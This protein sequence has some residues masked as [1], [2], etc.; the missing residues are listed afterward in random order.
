MALTRRQAVR[1]GAPTPAPTAAATPQAPQTAADR[2]WLA[3]LFSAA[4]ELPVSREAAAKDALAKEP[5]RLVFNRIS[6]RTTTD[7]L[8]QIARAPN[9][10]L[11][12][13]ETP[14]AS[15][16]LMRAS[17]GGLA[18]ADPT[19]ALLLRR[20]D[21]AG[22][23][24]RRGADRQLA[25]DDAQRLAKGAEQVKVMASDSLA[26]KLEAEYK[27]LRAEQLPALMQV[28]MVEHWFRRVVL[29]RHLARAYGRPASAALAQ[30][31]LFDPDAD[32]R[33]EAI[34]SLQWRPATEYRDLLLRGFE[35][36]WPVVAEHA[37]E[38]LSALRRTETVP[39]LVALLDA[40]DPQAPYARG[41]GSPQYIKEMVRID[42]RL[43]CLMCHPP[44]FQA[45]DP[46]RGVIPRPGD[47]AAGY[48]ASPS[49]RRDETFVRADI[50]YLKQ[51]YSVMLPADLSGARGERRFDLFVRE[52]LVTKKDLIANLDRVLT[53]QSTQ[54]ALSFALRE[55]TGQEPGRDAINWKRFAQRQ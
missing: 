7:V 31:A 3:G 18:N 45:T 19:L 15:A 23:P 48:Y 4:P 54:K 10:M 55:L 37:A 51:D 11:D 14:T 28:L 2:F 44:S 24:L 20:T 50:T 34:I 42:H 25:L 13:T 35:F 9:L 6:T 26:S 22:L 46:A 39:A 36:P 8:T 49:P 38:A 21:L 41:N 5:P 40:A 32:V 12:T 30:M 16:E 52:R 27:W 43:N 53:G 29:A 17:A 47:P 33:R 1:A